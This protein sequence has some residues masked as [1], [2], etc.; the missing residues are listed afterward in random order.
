MEGKDLP[1]QW[2]GQPEQSLARRRATAA[3]SQHMRTRRLLL[4]L[5]V[6]SFPRKMDAHATAAVTTAS[7]EFPAQN[8]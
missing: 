3:S 1:E 6:V 8:G 5:P 4:P 7:G 2:T